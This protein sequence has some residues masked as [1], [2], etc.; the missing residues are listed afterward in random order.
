MIE[1]RVCRSV[2]DAVQSGGTIHHTVKV[3]EQVNRKCRPIGT[4][5]YNSCQPPTIFNAS[6]IVIQVSSETRDDWSLTLSSIDQPR[7]F[8]TEFRQPKTKVPSNLRRPK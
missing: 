6:V 7:K 4:G 2:C 5:Y 8:G 1:S 3:S